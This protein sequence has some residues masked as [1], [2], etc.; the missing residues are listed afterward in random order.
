MKQRIFVPVILLMLGLIAAVVFI[1]REH[2]DLRT[3]FDDLQAD[4]GA[5]KATFE[6]AVAE[7]VGAAVADTRAELF[8]GLAQ[9]D[10]RRTELDQLLADGER[11]RDQ[12]VK[13]QKAVANTLL[14]LRRGMHTI[15]RDL[16]PFEYERQDVPGGY[17]ESFEVVGGGGSGKATVNITIAPK[18]G[19]AVKPDIKLTF[20]NDY[21]FVTD[22]VTVRWLLDRIE[23]GER[24]IEQRTLDWK[25]GPPA[26]WQIEMK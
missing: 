9:L 23:P 4:H 6:R 12:A 14:V 17:V 11:V 25:Y 3:R 13:D 19:I 5:V 7:A 20:L 16:K 22:T 21:G 18:S 10:E 1:A 2:R 15:Y 26:Y 8:Q 24:R